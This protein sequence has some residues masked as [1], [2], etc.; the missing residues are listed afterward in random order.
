MSALKLADAKAH[1]NIT[2]TD[3]DGELQG[4][5]DS[6]EAALAELV[7]PLT[8]TATTSR[9]LGGGPY[10]VLPVSPA[11]ELASVTPHLGTALTLTDLWL[12]TRTGVVT[13]NS[14][15]GF[16]VRHYTVV[17]SAGRTSVP[18]DLTMAVKELVRHM[19]STQRG[20]TRRPGSAAS[21]SASNTLPGAAHI[22]P[23]RV[24]E[25]LG[26]HMQKALA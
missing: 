23:F 18:D 4:V 21:D 2:T 9:V 13:Q 6:A 15:A 20:V 19:W 16:P 1:L 11:I 17:Y 8:P 3:D 22:L 10:L 25:L 12:E 24:T 14:G 7:G 5:I 26:P